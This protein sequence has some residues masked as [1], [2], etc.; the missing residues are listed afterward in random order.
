LSGF[1][2]LFKDQGKWI[3]SAKNKHG[4]AQTT[5][6]VIAQGEFLGLV[7]FPSGNFPHTQKE[8]YILAGSWK[9]SLFILALSDTEAFLQSNGSNLLH[10]L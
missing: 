1:F 2:F 7:C 10:L 8:I 5:C 3:C 9:S 4:V 6:N